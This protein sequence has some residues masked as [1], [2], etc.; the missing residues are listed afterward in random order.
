VVV[1][2][3][4]IDC[5][6]N[7]I[8]CMHHFLCFRD[9]EYAWLSYFSSTA[10]H[11]SRSSVDERQFGS[12]AHWLMMTYSCIQ[13]SSPGPCHLPRFIQTTNSISRTKPR[14]SNYVVSI[15]ISTTLL[16]LSATSPTTAPQASLIPIQIFTS[17]IPR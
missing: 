4:H 11:K 5:C 7:R 3:H 10:K 6:C 2:R 1:H 14:P 12:R 9:E 8:S 16:F 13:G 15:L 17:P